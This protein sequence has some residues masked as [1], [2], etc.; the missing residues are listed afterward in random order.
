VV[1]MA[2]VEEVGLKREKNWEKEKVKE[3]NKKS[4]SNKQLQKQQ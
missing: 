1:V 4:G 2:A 3:K